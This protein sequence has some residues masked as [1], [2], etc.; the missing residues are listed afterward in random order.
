MTTEARR[1]LCLLRDWWRL[2]RI[3]ISPEEGR[4]LRLRP[5]ALLELDGMLLQVMARRSLTAAPG[6]GY[7]CSGQGLAGELRV[8][9][10][11]DRQAQTVEWIRDGRRQR[12]PAAAIRVYAEQVRNARGE[13]DPP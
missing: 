1:L 2:D 9:L 3:R 12:L 11:R 10:D 8:G 5:G 13:S 7:Y 6:V 4:L